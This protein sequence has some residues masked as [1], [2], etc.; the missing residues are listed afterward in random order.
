MKTNTKTINKYPPKMPSK[1]RLGYIYIYFNES[2]RYLHDDVYKIGRT[3]NPKTRIINL[4]TSQIF[5]GEYMYI[6]G[7][8]KDCYKAEGEIKKKLSKLKIHHEIYKIDINYAIK[9]IKNIINTI[10]D[11]TLMVS[12]MITH[13]MKQI[14]NKIP[15]YCIT[16]NLYN[17][18]IMKLMITLYDAI[19]MNRMFHST[20]FVMRNTIPHNKSIECCAKN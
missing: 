3:S 10:N 20:H 14:I 12:C 8:C 9:V 11:V 18:A 1:T 5:Y 19:V 6:S 17:V 13:I 15:F 7:V 16:M 2:Y 4:N